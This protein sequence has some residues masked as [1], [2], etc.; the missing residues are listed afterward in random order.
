MTIACLATLVMFSASQERR[1]RASRDDVEFIAGALG[2]RADVEALENAR[3]QSLVFERPANETEPARHPRPETGPPSP[4]AASTTTTS[5]PSPQTEA[6]EPVADDETFATPAPFVSFNEL[7]RETDAS[8]TFSAPDDEPLDEFS[9]NDVLGFSLLRRQL[10]AAARR[11]Q[12]ARRLSPFSP[13][14]ADDQSLVDKLSTRH[15]AS[16]IEPILGQLM[17]ELATSLATSHRH[18]QARS[19]AGQANDSLHAA[20]G[21]PLARRHKTGA[22][23][24]IS[25]ATLGSNPSAPS[26]LFERLFGPLARFSRLP[27]PF[28]ADQLPFGLP[29]NALNGAFGSPPLHAFNSAPEVVTRVLVRTP[30]MF[31]AVDEAPRASIVAVP[32]PAAFAKLAAANASAEK[33]PDTSGDSSRRANDSFDALPSH[34]SSFSVSRD[35]GELDAGDKAPSRRHSTNFRHLFG[36]P[37]HFARLA[38]FAN[39][40]P[41]ILPPKS[42]LLFIGGSSPDQISPFDA[43]ASTANSPA[44]PGFPFPLAF[45]LAPAPFA[46]FARHSPFAT[47]TEIQMIS[48]P[49]RVSP[50]QTQASADLDDGE[51][52]SQSVKSSSRLAA[53][54]TRIASRWLSAGEARE[55]DASAESKDEERQGEQDAERRIALVDNI[56]SRHKDEEVDVSAEQSR[57]AEPHAAFA[58]FPMFGRSAMFA[59]PAKAVRLQFM[60]RSD[61]DNAAETGNKNPNEQ[62]SSVDRSDESRAFKSVTYSDEEA[63]AGHQHAPSA[64]IGLIGQLLAGLGPI[65]Q[66]LSR[67][68]ES[69]ES[70]SAES[71]SDAPSGES[72]ADEGEPRSMRVAS[73]RIKIRPFRTQSLIVKKADEKFAESGQADKHRTIWLPARAMPGGVQSTPVAAKAEA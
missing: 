26:A 10:A 32:P 28:D 49:V 71:P 25:S 70:E 4:A 31:S 29:S 11:R 57:D 72:S 44:A 27:T 36:N 46:G 8:Q 59:Q 18:Q 5:Q 17:G 22:T 12:N 2:A 41:H 9:L 69:S 39:S 65:E 48:M 16:L 53:A 3:S 54:P 1:V 13:A 19:S 37:M 56:Q 68:S 7:E 40:R 67:V 55:L 52:E 23:I 62:S 42:S 34:L 24:I 47:P 64:P 61:S 45:P 66:A 33:E 73:A 50:Q 14:P 58:A 21:K 30:P 43:A 6:D 38:H 35:A 15:A 51:N 63:R 60:A 20:D